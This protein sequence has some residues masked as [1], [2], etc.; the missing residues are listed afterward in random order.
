MVFCASM[1]D[2]FEDHPD[3]VEARKRLWGLI[4]VTPWLRWQLLTKRPENVTGMVPWGNDWPSWVWLGTSI[5]NQRYAWT[6][7]NL[8]DEDRFSRLRW[9]DSIPAK[10]KFIS[11]EPLLGPVDLGI[12]DPHAT[13][14]SDYMGGYEWICLD[15]S[16]EEGEEDIRWFRREDPQPHGISWVI[17]GGESGPKARP[18]SLRWARMLVAECQS[19]GVPVFVKQLGAV[20]GRELGAGPK[21]GDWD[22]WPKDLQIRQFPRAAEE[23]AA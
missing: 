12:G 23:V 17:I 3:V 20:L 19:A 6:S 22:R 10:V 21:G 2:V 4:E 15:C 9:L 1:A 8:D 18:M 11:A 14:A 16:A 13:H 5:E 7:D